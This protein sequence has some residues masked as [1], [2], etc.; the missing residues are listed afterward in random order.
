[1]NIVGKG[2]W[3]CLQ[4]IKPFQKNGC[5]KIPLFEYF[6]EYLKSNDIEAK[7]IVVENG[8]I[9]R[10]FLEDFSAYYVRCFTDY[11]RKCTR[12]HFF[13]NKFFQD[14]FDFFLEKYEPSFANDLY[15]GYL[16]FIVLKPLPQTIIGRTCLKTYKYTTL[17]GD[18]RVFPIIREN[19][20]NL[21]GITLSVKSLA[22]QEQDSVVSACATS[23]LWSAFQVTAKLFQHKVLSPVEITKSAAEHFALE[24]R[25]FPNKGLTIMQMVH[26]VRKLDMEPLRVD[27]KNDEYILK[28]S[29]YAYLTYDIPDKQKTS[30][31]PCSEKNT[32]Y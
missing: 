31:H 32:R 14:E 11:K 3:I 17:S 22:F 19:K 23:A 13:N 27:V 24:E 30:S 6:N 9:D 18:K 16:G 15:K 20:V 26:A 4:K 1:M 12:L 5:Q 21:C 25:P 2:Y 8:Y 7:T 29:I 28:S 10:D